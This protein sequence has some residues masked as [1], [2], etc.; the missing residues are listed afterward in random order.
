MRFPLKNIHISIIVTVNVR[1]KITI[2][3]IMNFFNKWRLFFSVTTINAHPYKNTLWAGVFHPARKC[4]SFVGACIARPRATN[5][6]PL[7]GEMSR[8]DKRVA[9]VLR[10]P[11]QSLSNSYLISPFFARTLMGS[12]KRLMK[13]ALSF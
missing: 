13:P 11:L 8:S 9:D 12:P 4:I 2:R 5:V 10:S 3:A 6:I 7:L 1:Q